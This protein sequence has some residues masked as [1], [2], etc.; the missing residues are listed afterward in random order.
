MNFRLS[1]SSSSSA[2]NPETLF[3]DIRD[4]RVEGLLS[5][6][7]DML[8]A[9]YS[10]GKDKEDVALEMPTGS[11]K[12]LV[13]L[14][15]AEWRRRKFDQRGLYLCPTNQLVN[16]VVEQSRD[17][18]GIPAIP[19]TGGK[20]SF[21]ASDKG[22]YLAAEAIGVTSYSSLF[23]SSPFF[24]N[25][26][27][28]VLDD[29]HAAE[30]YISDMWALEVRRADRNPLFRA[31]VRVLRPHLDT[32][33]IHRLTGE[34]RDLVDR[35]WTEKVP[36]PIYC[37]LIP[38]IIEVLDERLA[39][40]DDLTFRWKQLRDHLRGCH[41][42][43]SMDRIL[44][45]PLLPPT[46]THTPFSEAEQRL[47][48]SATLG[49]GGE[50]ERIAGVP[51]I[52][53]LEAPEG[54]DEQGVGRR[55]F[56]LPL[57]SQEEESAIGTA[58]RLIEKH[59]RSLVLTPSSRQAVSWRER[60]EQK[61]EYDTFTAREI[62]VSK[63]PFI[64]S[65]DA[66]AIVANRYDGIDLP[67]DQCRLLIVDGVPR[68]TN[69]QERF[70]IQRLGAAILYEDR[71]L[72]RIVQATGR[73]TRSATDYATV[74]LL[75]EEL[76]REVLK[77]EQRSQLH[78]EIQAELEFGIAESRDVEADD[79]VAFDRILMNRGKEWRRAEDDIVARR[80]Q[81]QRNPLPGEEE[82]SS[83]VRHE[84]DYQYAMWRED[85]QAAVGAG[86][87]ALGELGGP[88]LR[89]Y[90]A[91]WNYL[92]GGAAWQGG[93][94][95]GQDGLLG[96]ARDHFSRAAKTADGVR[97]MAR[98][99]RFGKN[100]DEDTEPNLILS[101]IENL[102]RMFEE[103]GTVHDRRF[104]E[105]EAAL[106]EK[107]ASDNGEAFEQGVEALGRMI[108]YSAGNSEGHGAPDPWWRINS[109]WCLVFEVYSEAD[110]GQSIGAKKARQVTNHPDWI[111]ENIE[112]ADD[113]TIVPVL[114]TD[115][116]SLDGDAVPLARG[117]YHWLLGDFLEW[118]EQVM[119]TIRNLR[120][121]FR[122]AGDLAWR[123][124][125]IDEVQGSTFDPGGIETIIQ[126]RPLHE[127]PD[128]SSD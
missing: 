82:L 78:P 1:G 5:Q 31:L 59:D 105:E 66:V 127:L 50:L 71:I 120:N 93:T 73:C 103:L 14:L 75:G 44:I 85:F 61:V 8:R 54:W 57:R 122:G 107:L 17:K 47:Y 11:G 23:N 12:T 84:I 63:D 49:A 125:A 121:G 92:V 102:E 81:C 106:F 91:F 28:L 9:Y 36:T 110:E 52:C 34:R 43:L 86:R 22:A 29:I 124:Q 112:V 21:K 123:A 111:R 76:T 104:N 6:Q 98:V 16:Q 56:L 83:A 97:W 27:T 100:A 39:P 40:G 24:E 60:V 95:T 116:S 41:M 69:L 117:A 80:E 101:Q 19:F 33:D 51:K 62:E 87:G 67:G 96:V 94:S 64:T 99:A 114:L 68:A 2:K 38:D 45:R 109:E 48:M 126:K 7:A 128:T 113:A 42:Y 70:L 58:L 77:P 10:S 25:P 88:E 26:Q 74:V 18:Y 53:R 72:T 30:N 20:R 4:R 13:G 89:G 55:L 108:G 65:A 90:R 115:A 119:A 3:R 79:F 37:D 15:I 118:A 32:A 35:H 46:L